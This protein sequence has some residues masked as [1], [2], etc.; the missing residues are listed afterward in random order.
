[1]IKKNRIPFILLAFICLIVGL[2]AGL[3]RMGWQS[4]IPNTAPHHGAIMI[5]GFLGTLISLEKIIPLKRKFLFI[6]PALSALSIVC[7]VTNFV[8]YGYICLLAASTGLSIVFLLYLL[9]EKNATYLLMFAGAQCWLI[10]NIKL[11]TTLFYPA[12]I[13][14]WMAFALL[15]ITSERLELMKFLPV[16]RTNKIVFYVAVSTFLIGCGISFHGPG[17]IVAGAALIVISI[18]LLRYDLVG[19]TIKKRGLTRYVGWTLMS[20]YFA[21]MM[22][23]LFLL[24]FDAEPYA[25]DLL[26]HVFFIGF[27]FSM[28]FAHGPIILPGVLGISTKPYTSLFYLWAATLTVSIIFRISGSIV[29]DDEIKKYSGLMSAFS[30]LSYFITLA[31]VTFIIRKRDARIP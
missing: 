16:T 23:G 1:M 31:T 17:S 28:I 6:I 5:G 27:V 25:Y 26:I 8:V 4:L 24:I 7:F 12:A 13:P 18:W 3:T 19:I 29:Y 15:V 22:T 14:W 21:L 2:G 9:K 30:I 10:G 20:G 11:L